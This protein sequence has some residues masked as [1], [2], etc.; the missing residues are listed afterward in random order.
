MSPVHE[1]GNVRLEV[2]MNG[3]D[4]TD[5]GV[6]FSY[7]AP[8]I[9]SI[10]PVLGPE[11]GGTLVVINGAYM[12]QAATTQCR[13]GTITSAPAVWISA[14]RVQCVV[15]PMVPSTLVLGISTEGTV[16]ALAETPFEVQSAA[17]VY[18]VLPDTGPVLGGT[19]V[20][21]VGA[22]FSSRSASLS[23]L[24]CRFNLTVSSAQWLNSSA[25][26]CTAPPYE[27]ELGVTSLPGAVAL[28]MT[29]N[30]LDFTDSLVAFTYVPAVRLTTITPPSGP[31][32]GGALVTLLGENFSPQNS[33]CRFGAL[34]VVATYVSATTVQCVSPALASNQE[35]IVLMSASSNS[36][37]DFSVP[38][39]QFRYLPDVVVTSLAPAAGPQQGRTLVSVLGSGYVDSSALKCKFGE[40]VVDA[41]F[42]SST[43]VNCTAPAQPAGA[44]AL[45]VS[46]N[47]VQFSSSNITYVYLQ[48][49]SVLFITPSVGPT[50]G[51]TN[52]TVIGVGLVPGSTCRFG[53]LAALD[54]VWVSYTELVCVSPPTTRGT[55]TIEVTS[56]LQDY[57]EDRVEFEF[58]GL[59][60]V[61]SVAPVLGP[62]VGG[63]LIQVAGTNFVAGSGLTCRF[64]A[65][66]PVSA[67]L[68]S[69]TQV[70]CISPALAAGNVTLE[71]SINNQDYSSSGVV[72]EV[73][74][75][76]TVLETRPREGPVGGGTL[77]VVQGAAYSDRS[78]SLDYIF[79]RFGTERSPGRYISDEAL[80]CVSPVHAAGNVTLEV[81]MNGQ[82]YT[83]YGVVFSYVAPT[84]QSIYPVLGP[85]HGGTVVTV[86]ASFLPPLGNVQCL[87][88]AFYAAVTA[89]NA[90]TITCVTPENAPGRV[91]L[92]VISYG[93][94]LLSS[95][96]SNASGE[97]RYH[98]APLVEHLQPPSGPS[99]GGSSVYVVGTGFTRD[100]RAPLSA[101][102]SFGGVLS[103]ATVINSTTLVCESPR[104]YASLVPVEVSFN[105]Q[106]FSSSGVIYGFDSFVITSLWPAM[107]PPTGG[108]DVTIQLDQEP[109]AG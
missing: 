106:D 19:P 15:P 51:G 9:Q 28:R 74:P 2:T 32:Q 87:F 17:V 16:S 14:S 91:P 84:I 33:R 25:L 79:C 20:V 82:D 43:V 27:G 76:V 3:Q 36:G 83:D 107:G 11:H 42:V 109:T 64:G 21:L 18:S 77:V 70:E 67:Q 94:S 13:F 103:L 92:Q 61:E 72:F 86:V 22:H 55:Y 65:G 26:T 31:A 97:F 88:G 38:H 34:S 5:Y 6:V 75:V 69:R 108:T 56:N 41:T 1:A 105:G 99:F 63:V 62:T 78:A 81:T 47:T 54:A 60:T 100:V 80:E 59:P 85:E 52:T 30:L 12:P 23:Y 48:P 96:G 58:V 40:L 44:I 46:S 4:Y 29:N 98:L 10:Y 8:T 93:T 90:S 50:S 7:V 39:L 35:Q 101:R 57:T 71:V 37:F 24:Q 45:E 73:L 49:V 89:H 68:I 104:H 53:D 66:V 102:C 95:P